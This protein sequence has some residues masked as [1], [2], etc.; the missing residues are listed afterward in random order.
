MDSDFSGDDLIKNGRKKVYS[1]LSGLELSLPNS[2][3]IDTLDEGDLVYVIQKLKIDGKDAIRFRVMKFVDSP[4]EVNVYCAEKK[5]FKPYFKDSKSNVDGDADAETT[6][7][8]GTANS[9]SATKPAP[10]KKELSEKDYIVPAITTLGGGI[11]AY[12]VAQK[13]GKSKMKFTLVGLGIG[14]AVGIFI[15]K[16]NEKK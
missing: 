10:K 2:N 6:S 15:L 3:V 12:L 16:N 9:S 7:T 14:L 1:A 8:S 13:Y 5:H 11:F 4:K